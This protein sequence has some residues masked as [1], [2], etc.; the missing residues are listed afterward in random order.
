MVSAVLGMGGS[1]E[2]EKKGEVDPKT[3]RVIEFGAWYRA[4]FESAQFNSH[5][6]WGVIKFAAMAAYLLDPTCHIQKTR[7]NE[8]A[9]GG[10]IRMKTAILGINHHCVGIY[11]KLM[12]ERMVPWPWPSIFRPCERVS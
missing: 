4:S 10:R 9:D 3:M 5:S 2:D 12:D 7:M 6:R 1:F 8:K 11:I